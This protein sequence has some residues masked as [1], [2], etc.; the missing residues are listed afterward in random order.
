MNIGKPVTV[1]GGTDR[2]NLDEQIHRLM[3][4]IA[5]LSNKTYPE[6]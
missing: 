1:K 4:Q 2:K 5:R 3:E 6:R